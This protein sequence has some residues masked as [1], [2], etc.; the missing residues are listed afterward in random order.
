MPGPV[1]ALRNRSNSYEPP[2]QCR[3][4]R[5]VEV[6]DDICSLSETLSRVSFYPSPDPSSENERVGSETSSL[7][8]P[9]DDLGLYARLGSPPSS[10]L[11]VVSRRAFT[12][13][14]VDS[15]PSYEQRMSLESPAIT[16]IPEEEECDVD[17]W[18]SG[19]EGSGDEIDGSFTIVSLEEVSFPSLNSS[20][21]ANMG[22]GHFEYAEEERGRPD[23][24]GHHRYHAEDDYTQP[25][26]SEH[27]AQRGD[28]FAHS[29][30]D[31]LPTWSRSISYPSYLAYIKM[32]AEEAQRREAEKMVLRYQMAV[33]DA[34]LNRLRRHTKR[35]TTPRVLLA[36][37]SIER[38]YPPCLLYH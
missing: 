32:R 12:F 16:P 11:S 2:A 4:S 17:D 34:I 35:R 36:R 33:A 5:T 9:S 19:S 20:P 23:Q 31:F 14:D 38:A 26:D 10:G 15:T 29:Q 1:F 21:Y 6:E 37:D 25:S 28:S 13:E 18:S 3:P 27:Y 22:P 8:E 24:Y 30:R 7:P